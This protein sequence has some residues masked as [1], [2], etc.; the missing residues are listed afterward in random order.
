MSFFLGFEK[1]FEKLAKDGSEGHHLR[2]AL[3]G[4]PISAAIE[5][6]RGHKVRAFRE[7]AA[8]VARQTARGSL[9]GG[10]GGAGTAALLS[11]AKGKGKIN[12]D[13]L[14]RMAARG[15][16]LGGTV[17]G[18]YGVHKGNHGRKASEIHG[19]YSKHK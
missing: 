2:R 6:K 7:A 13:L 10:L 4:N 1:S 16:L 9:V 19:K 11:L 3:L 17:G 8:E 14:T 15:G 18:T 5:A 12:K